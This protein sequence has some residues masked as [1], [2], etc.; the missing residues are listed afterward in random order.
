MVQAV[1]PSDTPS[2]QA[3]KRPADSSI[4]GPSRK[5]AHHLAPAL[6]ALLLHPCLVIGAT[7]GKQAGRAELELDDAIV[8]AVF[9]AATAQ[10]A[11]LGKRLASRFMPDF[12]DIHRTGLG[13]DPALLALVMRLLHQAHRRQTLEGGIHRQQRADAAERLAC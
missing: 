8:R 7:G 12:R 9:G 1:R 10:G 5:P 11:V 3:E 6:R 4:A 13:A 2:S